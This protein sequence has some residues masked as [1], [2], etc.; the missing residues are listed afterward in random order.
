LKRGYNFNIDD[1]ISRSFEVTMR[2]WEKCNDFIDLGIEKHKKGKR[3]RNF[4]F[5]DSDF[6]EKINT[7]QGFDEDLSI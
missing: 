6:F 3:I 2:I 1:T 5:F 4:L 7:N